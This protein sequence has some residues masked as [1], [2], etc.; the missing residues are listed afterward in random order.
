MSG[1][2]RGEI[3]LLGGSVCDVDRQ[4]CGVKRTNVAEGRGEIAFNV[5]VVTPAADLVACTPADDAGMVVALCDQFREPAHRHGM[6]GFDIVVLVPERNLLEDE[7]TSFIEVV[8]NLFGQGQVAQAC[9]VDATALHPVDVTTV[10]FGRQRV[11]MERI[12]GNPVR[13]VQP[14]ALTIEQQ[15]VAVDLDF[16]DAETF[17]DGFSIAIGR[18]GGVEMRMVEVPQSG[19]ADAKRDEHLT[20]S[21]GTDFAPGHDTALGV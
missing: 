20:A 5:W 11:A 2:V 1:T 4:T 8:Q 17:G 14:Y 9:H 6:I 19:L 3:W 15:A 7:H 18:R 10:D 16:A 21:G 13:T 12:V